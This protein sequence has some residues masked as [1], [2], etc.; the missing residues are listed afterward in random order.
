MLARL[1]IVCTLFLVPFS[2]AQAQFADAPHS[3]EFSRQF[4]R[5]EALGDVEAC[6]R[7]LSWGRM[8]PQTRDA[9]LRALREAERRAFNQARNQQFD[10]LLGSCRGGTLA[11]CD[12][13]LQMGL[14]QTGR[15]RVE[16]ARRAGLAVREQ[17]QQRQA[18]P[19]R[20]V[21]AAP[22]VP[23]ST[24]RVNRA[25]T[26]PSEEQAFGFLRRLLVWL[27]LAIPVGALYGYAMAAGDEGV[28]PRTLLH[29]VV[30]AGVLVAVFLVLGVSAFVG[31][32]PAL[33]N[34][35]DYTLRALTDRYSGIALLIAPLYFFAFLPVSL[36]LLGL[37][38]AGGAFAAYHFLRKAHCF[39]IGVPIVL[40]YHFVKHPAESAVKEALKHRRPLDGERLADLFS[41][42]LMKVVKPPAAFKS[43]NQAR[44]A[45]ALR[46]KLKADQE[47]AE[48]AIRR[49]QARAREEGWRDPHGR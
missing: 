44:R 28:V 45:E 33:I 31:L 16:A 34:F 41:F 29:P 48:E 21:A 6:R 7:A 40:H 5:C 47:L 32:V 39:A 8:D 3:A 10:A 36:G 27:L 35:F 46:D 20:T 43:R 38:F 37:C 25:R 22:V 4:Q 49:E 15:D 26:G 30:G 1:F 2:V 24:V 17:T 18:S 9:L 12:R 11:D 19:E 14:S 13:A 23:A 42:D